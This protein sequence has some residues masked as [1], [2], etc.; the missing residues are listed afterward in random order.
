MELTIHHT[1]TNPE[2]WFFASCLHLSCTYL[3]ISRALIM[4]QTHPGSYP[5]LQSGSRRTHLLSIPH[6]TRGLLC[7]HLAFGSTARLI[8]ESFP[9]RYR[10]PNGQYADNVM[11]SETL[12]TYFSCYLLAAPHGSPWRK[13][14]AWMDSVDDPLTLIAP[15]SR[16][17]RSAAPLRL[18]LD[19]WFVS[20]TRV[21][22]GFSRA[23]PRNSLAVARL[24]GGY[25]DPF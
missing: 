8:S 6:T 12:K 9:F 10:L 11:P 17:D 21:K 14:F 5:A 20:E 3:D 19:D 15:I 23:L 22:S 7:T 16:S 1:F 4:V 13:L 18:M 25:P 2:I 24:S